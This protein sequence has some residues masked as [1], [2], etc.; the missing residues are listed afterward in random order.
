MI[1]KI[2]TPQAFSEIG[3]KDNQEDYIQRNAR[4]GFV[5]CDGM[6]GHDN[7]E[8][9]SRIVA[10]TLVADLAK[11]QAETA[12]DIESDFKLALQH[13]YDAL[14]AADTAE[15]VKKMGTTMTTVVFGRW[16]AFVAHIGDSRI[17]QVRPSLAGEGRN[18]IV[19]QTCDHSLVNDLLRVGELTEEEARDFPQKNIITRAMQPHQD[20]RSK[21]DTYVIT[22][23]EAGD[24]FFMCCDGVLERLNNDALGGILATSCTDEQK[25]AAI[26]AICDEGTRDN[27]TCWLIPVESVLREQTDLDAEE[28][29]TVDVEAAADALEVQPDDAA[30]KTKGRKT[31]PNVPKPANHIIH[32]L[33]PVLVV[34]FALAGASWYYSKSQGLLP[35]AETASQKSYVEKPAKAS[36]P[37][38]PAKGKNAAK[39]AA[40]DNKDDKQH[41]S[42]E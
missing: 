10:E 36:K 17:Y 8:V 11:S 9:A 16:G 33:L 6:G 20:R 27:Y 32:I 22:D 14:D 3:L 39:K 7:G 18:G 28:E 21:A 31:P 38:K 29:V 1:I 26:K 37:A 34:V 24:Y 25:L 41:K 5:L 30:A 2:G 23:V 35:A 19:Y 13:A 12:A 42:N 15:S 4:G 40:K